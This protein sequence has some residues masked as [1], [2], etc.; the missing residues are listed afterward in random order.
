MEGDEEDGVIRWGNWKWLWTRCT[1]HMHEI[2]KELTV[3]FKIGSKL[4]QEK[5]TI[6]ESDRG[7]N[8]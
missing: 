1:I 6:I 5:N 7:R 3:N 2:F 8:E 4:K